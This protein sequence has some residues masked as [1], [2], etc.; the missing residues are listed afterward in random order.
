MLQQLNPFRRASQPST[1]SV[2]TSR[3]AST[4]APD[5]G[6]GSPGEKYEQQVAL[7]LRR[8]AKDATEARLSSSLFT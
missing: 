5:V 1:P 4:D 6:D 7:A 2:R 8:S 3:Q